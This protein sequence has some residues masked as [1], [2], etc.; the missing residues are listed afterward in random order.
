[1]AIRFDGSISYATARLLSGDDFTMEAWIR[2][3]SSRSGT[4]AYQ[5]LGFLYADVAGGSS[6]DFGLS[7]TSQTAAF[8]IGNPDTTLFGT[9]IVSTGKW[10]H[11][12]VTRQKTSG[13]MSI[14]VNGVLDEETTHPNRAS[15]TSSPTLTIGANT[16][17]DRYYIGDLDEVRVWKVVRSPAQITQT[18]HTRLN[19]SE[20][21]LE[22]YYRFD[23]TG[24]LTIPDVSTNKATRND[25]TITGTPTFVPSDA[26]IC[27]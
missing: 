8:V 4:G 15:L 7:I 13:I 18:L 1:M 16:V 2:T 24:G 14:I 9:V 21:G 20:T 17:S 10:T 6:N 19:G 23:Q 25:A 22:E 11:V 3:T 12:A 27:N 26:P 5:G